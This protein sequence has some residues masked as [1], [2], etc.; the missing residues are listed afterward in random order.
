MQSIKV[1]DLPVRLCHWTLAAT[2]LINL[3]ITEEGS[4]PHEYVG[5]VAAGVVVFRL[6]WGL[7]GTKHARFSD[8]FPTP[9]RIKHHFQ[10]LAHGGNTQELGHNPFAA[11]MMFVLWGL[12][13]TLGTTG[14]MMAEYIDS[15]FWISDLHELAANSLIPCIVLHIF[16]AVAMS[17]ISKVNLIKAMITGKKT[18]KP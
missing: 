10:T 4:P 6:I 1:W 2:V 18:F 17:H 3:T 15:P 9:S 11:L 8:F 14:Y 12:V 5:Y 13:L 16:A 7:I